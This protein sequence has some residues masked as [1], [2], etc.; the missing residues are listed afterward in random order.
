MTEQRLEKVK[1]QREYVEH[2][3]DRAEE[4]IRVNGFGA[5]AEAAMRRRHG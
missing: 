1:A 2:L 3:A 4:L 5:S